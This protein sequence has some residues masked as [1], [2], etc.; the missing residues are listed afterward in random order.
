MGTGIL[1][2]LLL[3]VVA[4]AANGRWCEQT[5]QVTE[6]EVV[7][8]RRE[9]VVP[10]PS[11]Y[12][13]SLEGWRIDRDRM[14]QAYGGDRGV[15][16]A[17]AQPD[18]G[19]PMCYVYKPPETRPAVRNRTV[20]ACCAGWSG[21]RCTE[22]EGS[23]GHCYAGWQCQDAPGA[24]NL[25]AVSMAECCRQPWGH[26][27]RNASSALCFACTHQPLAGDVP[28]PAAPRGPAARRQR[29][30]ASCL[31]WAGS[32]Y[33]SFDGRHFHFQGECAYSL[34]ASADGTWAVT[35]A[36]G[37]PQA[38]HMTFGLDT[39]VARGRNVSVN[40]VVV[41]EGQPHLHSGISIT[42]LGDFVAVESGLGVRVKSDG[43]GTT[44]VTVGAELRGSTRGL[45]GPYNDDPTDDFLR[46]GGDVAPFAASF[47]NSWRIPDASSELSCRDA[48]E[49]GPSCASGSAARRAAEAVCGELLAE[50]FSQ[51]HGAVEPHGFYEACLDVHC[52]EGGA[53][54]SPPH[55][56]CDTF[57]GYVR[58]CAQR[59]A[60]VDWRRPGFCERQCG[61]G[62][63][64][65][66]CVSSCP[67]SCA[68]AG[69]AEEGH[70]RDDCA[71]GC[72]CAPGLYLAGGACVPQSACPCH[73]GRRQYAPGQSIR[74]R[75]NQCTCR[76]GHWLCTQDRCAAEC[77][78]LGDLHY[79]TFDHRS[80]S[81]PGA[82][83]YTLVQ[84]FVEG[85]L[86]I[87]AEQEACGGRQPLSCLRALS[88]TVRGTSARLRSTGEV[89][90]NGREVP[91]PFA[92]AAL[93]VRRASSSFL[94]LQAFGTHV[95]WGLETPTVYITLQPVFA[96]KV[97]GLCGTYNWD[98]GDEFTTPAGDVEVGIA[99]FANKYRVSSA[100]PVLGPVPFEPCSTYAPRRELAS[101][102]CA[103]LHGAPFQPC[104]HL[105]DREPF[106]QLCLYDVCAC[107]AGKQCLCP[108]LAAY[109]RQCAQEGAALSWRN[110]SFCGVQCSGGQ[111][112]Q[113]CSSP[114]GRTCAD[115]RLDG[116][117]SCPDLDG[118]CV[119]G[120]NCPEGLVLDDGGQC[121]PKDVCPCQHGGEL[122]PPGSKIRQGCNACVCT[123]GAWSC[124]DAPCPEAAFCPGDL[125]YA[126]G[127]CLR[128]C[129][130]TE[131]NGT[132]PGLA[133][134]C[135]CP[136]GTVFLDERCVPPEECPCQHSGRLYQP[137]D[138]IVRDCNTCVCHRQRWR[139][140]SEDCAGT[141][142][143]TGDPHYITF[144]GKAF[145][146]L[147]D[148]EYVLVRE[149]GGLF[150]VT[151][152]N[153][154][155]GTSGVTCTKS[156]VVV[157]GNTVVHMLRGRDVTVNGVS[158]RPPKA[159]SGNGLTLQRAGL[160]LLL[161]SRLGLAVL[162]DGGTR[163]YVRLHPQH[164]GRVAGLCGNF[165]RDVENDLASRQG[166][167][168]PTAEL[169]GNS[170]RVSLLCPE[171]D[172]ADTQ[173]PCA[174]NPHRATWAR[175]RC[176]ILT[177][178]LFAPC[179][180]EVPCQ[181][182]YDWCV[183]DACGCDSGGDCECLCTAIA[184]YAEECG[185]RGVHIRWRS[186]DLCPMQCDGGQEY[187]AC[188][189]PCPQTCQNFG[190][191]LPEH[192]DTMSC[193]EGCFCPEGKV[194]HEGSCI[195]P[196]ECPCVWEGIAF[197]AGAGVQ[198]GCRNCTCVAGLWQC[199]PT[200]EPCPSQPRC[201]DSEF[202]CR[203]SGHCVPGAWLCDNED[204]CGDGS[205]EV[206]APRCA[207]HQHRCAGGQCVPWGARCD[208]VPDCSDGS[209]E[210]GCPPPACAPP[211]F[212]C[213]SGRCIPR[214]RVCDGELDCGF[215][216][217]SDEAGC[218]PTCGTGEFRCA[219][220][221]CVPYPHRCDGHDDCGDFSDERDCVCPAGRFQCP[222][223][224]CLPLAAVCDGTEDC[225][226]GTDE[227]FCPGRVTCAPGQLPCPDGSCIGQA[228]LCDGVWDCRDGWDESPARC[229]V[230]WA[231]AVPAHLPTAPA[232]GTA[233]PACGPYEFP[234]QSGECTPR[235]WLCDSEADCLDGS[236][237]LGCNRSCGLGHF[238]CTLGAHCIPHGHLCDGVPHCPDH[239]DESADTCGSTQIPPCPGHFICNDRVC[240]NASRV[241]DGS[242]DCP[243]GEDELACEGHVPAEG[244]NRT[245][246]PCT[247]YTCGDGECIAFKQVCNGLPDCGD[248]DGDAASGWV[249]SDERDC[250]HWGLWAPWGACSRSCG[251][252]QQLRA[253]GCSQQ[254]PDVLHQCHGEATQARPCFSTACPV[255]GAWSEWATW[256]NCT[257][258]CEGV[259]VRQRHCLPPRDGGRPCAALPAAAPATLEIG[260]CQQDG[261]PPAACP[262]GL[263]H[264]PCAPCPASCADLASRAQCRREKPCAPGCWCPEGLVLDGERGCVRPRECRCEVEG[265]RY[266]PGQRV[267]LN[268]RLCTCLDG[269]PRRCRQNPAC[270]VS[271]SWSPWSPWGE[272]LGPCGVQSIQWSFRS[273]SHPGKR[274]AGRQCRGIYR[275][276]RRCQTEPCQA[277]EHQGRSRA[278]GDRWRSGPCRVCQCLPGPQVRCSPYCAH[279]AGGCP[280]GQVLVEGQGDSCCFCAWP[281]DN[282]TAVPTELT[283]E[284]AP[285]SVPAEPPSSPLA[286]FP[287]P[288]PGDPCY[289]PL[290]IASLPDSSFSAS[291]AQEEHPAPAARLHR[292]SPGAEL[293]GWAPPADVF[294]G[295]PSQPP[296]L[297]LDLLQPTNLTGVVLQG[298]GAGEAFVTAFQL[299]FSTDG[300]RWHDYRQLFQGNLDAV[301]PA[302]QPLGRMV[303]AQHVRI[304]PRRFHNRI[305]LRAELLGCPPVPPAP[306]GAVP[307]TATVMAMPTPPPCGA[308]EFWCGDG[309]VGASRR[310]DGVA[311]CTGGAD[312]AGCEPP[313]TAVPT[314]PASPPAP[315]SAGILGLTPQPP[316]APPTAPPAEPPTAAGTGA[317]HPAVLGPA[318]SGPPSVPTTAVSPGV[319]PPASPPLPGIAAVTVTPPATG[320]P[321]L[322]LPPTRVPTPTAAELLLPRLLCPR[323]QFPCDVLGCVDAAAVCDGQ[324]D[325]LDGS[326]EVHCGT[327]PASSSP[328]APLVWPPGPPPTC[329]PKQFS[330]GTGECL[331]LAKRCDLHRDCADGSDESG[332]ADCILSPWG[333]W[334]E[335]SRSCGLGVTA[336]QRAVLRGALPGGTCL[337]PHLDTRS[338]FLRACPVPGAWAAWGAWSPCDAE[339][340]G[341]VRSRTRSCTDPPPKNGGQPCP[342]EALQSQPCNLQPCGDSQ[343]CGPGM[344]L[345][346][347][348]DCAQGLVP[349]C[350]QAC[351]DLGATTSCQSPCQEGCR[352]LPGLFLQE[353]ACVNASQCHCH[354]GQQRWLPG[355]VFLRDN[356]SQCVCLDGVVTCED[357]ACPLACGWSAWSPWTPCDRSCGV[358]MQERFRSPS[359]PAAAHGGAPCDGD[360][361]EV[362][363][364]HTPCA[365]EPSSGWSA[366][367][368][369][370]PCSRSCFHHVDHRGRRRRFRH[371]EGPGPVGTCPGLGEQE[372]PCDTAPCPVAGVWMPWSSWSEC[373][374]PCDAGVQTRSRACAPPA[375][376]GAECAGPLLQTRECNAQPCGAQCPGSMRYRTAE[377]CRSEGGPCPRLCRDLGPGVVCAARCQPGCHCP[378]GLLLQNG[379]CV[380]PGRCLC[381][382]RGRLY[383]PGDTAALDACNNCTCM[384]GEMV[385]GTEPCPVPC[386][387]SS[388]TAWSSCSRSCDVG[389]RRRYRVPAVPPPAGGGRPCQGPSMEVEFCSLQPCRAV[390]PWGPW[391]GCSVPCGGG[392]RNR[393]RGGSPLHGLEFSTCNPAPCPG[394][395]P[396]VCPPGKQW[397]PCAH[398]PAS[399]A[400]LSA[401]PPAGGHCHPG[402][403]CPPGALLLNDECVAEE[404]CP[405]ALDGVLYLPG[406]AVPR[407]CQNCSCI[408]GRVTNCSQVACGELQTPWTPWTPWSECSASCGPGHQRRYRFCTPQPGAPCSEPQSEER[409]CVLQPCASPDCAAVPG[410]VFSPCGPPCPRSC[411]D[412]SHCAWRCQP[413]CYCTGGALL[414]ALGTA[415][416]APENCTCLDLRS[417]QRHRPGHSVPRG[418]GCNN[419]TCTRGKLLC[420]GLPC[421]VPG[422][423]CEWSPWTPCSR[424]CGEE[425]TTRHRAC[426]CPT[427]QQGG[428][429][430]PGGQE[431]L[432]DAG[433]QLQRK[434]C[435]NAPPCPED[436]SWGAW[437]P[438]SQCG[439][440]GG[441]ALRTRA[442]SGPPARFGGQPCAGEARQSRPCPRG[443]SGCQGE[444]AG[445]L[446]AFACGKPCPRSCADLREDTACLDG[447][448]CQPACACPPGLLLQ[449]GACVPPERCRCPRGT[450]EEGSAWGWDG[451]APVQELQ[452]GETL[453]R[454][455][456]NCTCEAGALRCRADPECRVDG[457]WSPWGPWSR[458]SPGCRAGTQA[459]SR[460]CSNPAPQ[461]GG[462]GCPGH[463]QRQRPCPAAEGCPEEEPWGEWSPW[464]PCSVSCGGGEQLRQRDCPPPGGCPGLALQS[465]TCNTHVCR[466]AGC[467]PGR[468][469]RECQQGEG[470][471]YSCAHLAGRI[472]CFSGGCQEGCHCPTGTLLHRGQ[473]LQECP[474]VLT[475]EVLRELQNSSA[476]PQEAP[477]LL[478][479]QGPPLTL[480]QEVPPGSTLHSPC[481]ACTCL[482]GRLNCSQPLCPRDGGFAPWGPWSSCSRSCGGLGVRTRQR[483]CTSPSPARGGR[484]CAG[485]RSDSK[486]CQSP[487]CPAVAVPTE[488]PS[489]SVPGAEEEEGFGPWS[490]WS[491]CS[492]TCTRPER[493]ATKTRERFCTGAANCSGE[494]FQEQPCNLPHC[495]DAPPCQGEDCA[496]LNCSWTPW[497]PWAECSRSCG[498]GLQQR[499]R[500]YSPPG[501]GGR[502]CPGILSAYVQRRFCNLQ[503]CKV[504]G[505]WSGWSPWSRCDRTCGG[506]RA[507]RS[508]S[509]TRPP[510]K[511]GGQRCPGERH[512]L[513][514]CNPQPCGAGCPPGMALVACASRC[515]RRCEDLQ[516]GIACGDEER[517]EP[518]CRCPNGTLEQ[519]GGCVP[520]AHCEC[521]D[522]QG[523]SWVP[524]STHHD[525]CNNCT[526]REGRLRCTDRPCPPPHCPWSR[527]SRWSPCSVTCGDGQ[528]TRFRTPTSG[529]WEDECQGEHVESRGCAAGP[530]PPLCPQEGWERRLGDTWWQGECQQCTCTPE[531]TV[532]EDASCAG[533]EQCT[534]G[535]WSPCSQTCGTGL[536]TR[537]GSCP[538]PTPGTPGAPCNDSTGTGASP[539]RELEACYLQPCPDECSWSP[540]SPWSSC[541]CSSL[542]QHRHRHRH[543]PGT[544]VGLDGELRDCDTSGCSEASCEPPFEFQ[545][546]GPPCAQLCSSLQ[547]PQLCPA[548]PRCLPGCFCP[549]GLLE[550]HGACVPPE[551]CDCLHTNGSSG[552]VAL[553]P[554]SIVLLGCKKCVCQDGAL[555][556]SSEG[557]QGLLPLSPWSEWAPC[558]PCLPLPARLLP[559]PEEAPGDVVPQ[560]SLQHRYRACL[561]PET[562]LPW[563]GDAAA[564]SAELRQER[565]CPDPHVCQELCLW[566]PWGPWG[567]CQQPCSGGFRLR[568]RHLQN[569]A[570]SGQCPGASSQS[571]SCNTAVCP[572]E[573]CEDRGK[574]L[575]APCANDCPR[576]CADLWH[577]V[578]CV[579]GGCKPGCRCP[580]GQLLQD[581]ACVPI[582]EC[583]CGLPGANST[584]EV[585]PGEAAEV[586]C[587]NCT[588]VNGTLACPVLACPSYGPWSAWSPCSSSCGGGRISRHRACLPS[589]GGVPCTDTGTQETAECSPQPCPDGCQLS[590]WSPWSPCSASC[591]G[592]SS[593]R[594]REL[595][596]GEE[597]PCPVP[598]LQQH[599]VCNAHNCTPECPRSQVYGD[600]ANACPHACAHLRPGTQCLQQPCQPGCACLPGQVLQD[601]ACVPPEECRCVLDPTVPWA[602]NLSREEQEQEHAPGSRLQH[603]C[604]SCICLRGTFNCS[605]EDCSVDCLWSPWSPWSP[606][607][608]TCGAGERLSRRHPLRQRL[609]EGAECLGPPLRRAP[610]YLP[611]C[612]CPE[613]EHWQDPGVQGPGVPPGCDRSCTDIPSE[614]P[615]GCSAAPAP[616][617]ACEPGRYRNSS[618][619]CVPAALCEC[620]HRGQLHEPGSEW[621]EE[622][623]RCRCVDGRA[624]CT[625]G[626]PP[627]SC[628]EGE[629]KVREPGRC[630]PVCRTEWL[631]EPSSMCQRFTELR[632]ITKG[633]CS[634]PG[635]EV[636]YCSGRCRSRTAVTPEEPYLQTLCE[637]CSYRLDPASPVR[638][639]SLPCAGGTVEPVVL[640]V[641]HSCECSSCQGGDFSKR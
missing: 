229:I 469:Y 485:P 20:L 462:R 322:P 584:H 368:P 387:W 400:E 273:P 110:Q 437:G 215:A 351:G 59:Q 599:R 41:P 39:V 122:Y 19:T 324:P 243:Q 639:L 23:V 342:G 193:L 464:G 315:A 615:P 145:S 78:V 578:E 239:S 360:A 199:A 27:W 137:N 248:G 83:E 52:Q 361:R 174:E 527:W 22:G 234:C 471:P 318:T 218:S 238:P 455:C 535:A 515:P 441:Q 640:P 337:R 509:C 143:A 420:T 74:Q 571:E 182:F 8:P 151:A 246:G 247:E 496:G 233:A 580:P 148:C 109:A 624:A 77:A 328:P 581:G 475:A 525:G 97:R 188:G 136:P 600:C 616:S 556:C 134:G 213:A 276:A 627:L 460:Q 461:H 349:P 476:D 10:C 221:R 209:D 641:I 566:G 98:Q 156:V 227:A 330:C 490:P 511:N 547:R 404:A 86:L 210:R 142:V 495:S 586:E 480:D 555:R 430:C 374:A 133:D 219:A 502:W 591:G 604:N 202:A 403:S 630:C 466:E 577:H 130:N 503:A 473:C 358:G 55:A 484:D 432:G 477:T 5:V 553:A 93:T 46:V 113:E 232:N 435:P 44:Y 33:R 279:S 617:C 333:G 607:S 177:Q 183:F 447:P 610:C 457:G 570:G 332:C 114:C 408:A 587:H 564:C 365:P 270:T 254:A 45:C 132:C 278:L 597:E 348:G 167:L 186:Q 154:P 558:S 416:V 491:P 549:Q 449:D 626:C 316:P 546:C 314:H 135:V 394:E 505:A 483:G 494:S 260:P 92:S 614:A 126:V 506:G 321:A 11:M 168:E 406:D 311:D 34:A 401:A 29:P 207:P 214:A 638:I 224:L 310:C 393:T 419:C 3:W 301:T 37:S 424:T 340:Q 633:P 390:A 16:L 439:G 236:D 125:V 121:V 379:T 107:P 194:L 522:A 319:P 101:A 91:L 291:A 595:L 296:F 9:D 478:G 354:L 481:T 619:R 562:G 205:D 295:L 289:S 252:G 474:C 352:C 62:Q 636:S 405:C 140:G 545:P 149:A 551:Q 69:A 345:V 244:R 385:C 593:E 442:C 283:T 576:A 313:S 552:P 343:E 13:Y 223:A 1:A 230:S 501:T 250:G 560:V 119:S 112:F 85:T 178:R 367:T 487:E 363:E 71:S 102:A 249:P 307:V 606:C 504:D 323:D 451:A 465:K 380:P 528:Q 444:A 166:V 470:C 550:Q 472:A 306:L 410:S 206:C 567:P 184:T 391:S 95:L 165:D 31:A 588:C 35:I 240:V 594:R 25:S 255:D 344:V 269:Q 425:A 369:W 285:S 542:L 629:V 389:T 14:R 563:A 4:E 259:V 175:K 185:Q 559:Q 398:V 217:D 601:G 190:L 320:L 72:E 49:P 117:G 60:Y 242:L 335:C 258:D 128:T 67:A 572:G 57:A 327:P 292:V 139:C 589:P 445:Y 569:P 377:E 127:S 196:A 355:H 305:V 108:T 94:L 172:G 539:R 635:V 65:S 433:T 632:N 235:G 609:Y 568:H 220:G 536:A 413:G 585:W 211:E 621:Q 51:C 407:G 6:E 384:A 263:Q 100:C 61:R 339:C 80:F 411:D 308:G 375:F 82:C 280:Q 508:R 222:D 40:G 17:S 510:P 336:R 409:S 418:D 598:V 169:F 284:P 104:H 519:D 359:N 353:G 540:W 297:Q 138:T 590:P 36:M 274:G 116:A 50:P 573:V 231:T 530:C 326:D 96:N 634:L 341:G 81:F 287:L 18:S 304:L 382:H 537:Q 482:H 397:Q 201:P 212:R 423:W 448:R 373:S 347:A 268:C 32:R 575:A 489:P 286:T 251:P 592:G 47:G 399:C 631:E 479:T 514:L 53:G 544:C 402:C 500:A 523:H 507:V 66:D 245:A 256:S 492:K 298:A 28:L 90:V 7:S 517:C 350:P 458:C 612:A 453:Q 605:Q 88:V 228:K 583:R 38:L 200:A 208:G 396:G 290:G 366:W 162:W 378:A 161:L 392:Y 146:F 488:E 48:V 317:P 275:K 42:W 294:P 203:T 499:L 561:D 623:A 608:V 26:S 637:C 144:D 414:D 516:E 253:R 421:P 603:R 427:P 498:V 579:Q 277:C 115:L 338:C 531:G 431:G 226:A 371:C 602:L 454:P 529:S 357:L 554:G 264:R 21:P 422:G 75:C 141:C 195:D 237:E 111:V 153:V 303:Q 106:H 526:C 56:V 346:R 541:S 611:D 543:G 468:L 524:G 417:G 216:D 262:G 282:V 265:L 520:P 2:S 179:H 157:L 618:G 105:V 197:P 124:A 329:S 309:C 241:C 171:V 99:A 43:R 574:A 293:Q 334:S 463:S 434:E 170:W 493:P 521:T 622:C 54:P 58:D 79:V 533:P 625:D 312:E 513:R 159:Y 362:R 155:C 534:W 204:D 266:W 620:L 150:T 191:E 518:G 582:A 225:T 429:G 443:A 73:H 118:L 257:R 512:H 325:C 103:I 68:A 426:S 70:C 129:D 440:C 446:V 12:Q 388:W 76:G 163:V 271:C 383:Q 436:G 370:S 173:H 176:S 87:T 452:P 376:G 428:P 356:C 147:G 288:P 438:W 497:G 386:G 381:H 299:Q 84:D 123:A 267:K 557:C 131:L 412:I 548:L 189:P 459:A 261:C 158:V 450:P 596:G 272:C 538:C 24:R 281:G 63:R 198:Q 456:Q 187:S 120:C 331:A 372:E 613:G 302:V 89:E 395:E 30:A 180:D 628:P 164:R 15:P 415:C 160:F 152:E 486:Y 192:C 364:C 467:P 64:Y 532:C 300:T 565:L 181:R